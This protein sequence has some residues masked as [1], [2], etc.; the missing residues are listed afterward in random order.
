MLYTLQ[1]TVEEIGETFFVLRAGPFG[2][3]ILTN[4]KTLA[5]LPS[6]SGEMQVYCFLYIRDEQVELY[7]FPE[8]AG[9]KL[10]EMLN[11][12]AGVGPKTALGILDVESVPNIMAAIIEKRADVLAHA[13]GIGKKT[14][15]RI[16]LELHTKIKLPGTQALTKAMDI[17]LEVEEALVGLGYSRAQV[18]N[19]FQGFASEPKSVEDRL[20]EALRALG[21][22]R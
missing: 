3:K 9:L 7:G 13:S 20:R 11:T 2:F 8:E 12:V 10:F 4:K 22:G 16:I 18:K 21:R 19:A 6:G 14:A 15:E 1:G 5:S 17:N